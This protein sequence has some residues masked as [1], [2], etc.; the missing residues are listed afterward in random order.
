MPRRGPRAYGPIT[1]VSISR[2]RSMLY[3]RRTLMP[4]ERRK[5]VLWKICACDLEWFLVRSPSTGI[6]SLFAR[7]VAAFWYLWEFFCAHRR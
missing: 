3:R 7:Y 2:C 1:D 5:P 4:D 6:A